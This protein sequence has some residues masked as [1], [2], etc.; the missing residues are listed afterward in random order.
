MKSPFRKSRA[1]NPGGNCVEAGVAHDGRV[2][3]RD[4]K[5]PHGPVLAMSPSMFRRLVAAARKDSQ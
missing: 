3:V 2:L 4:T 5:T 1:S